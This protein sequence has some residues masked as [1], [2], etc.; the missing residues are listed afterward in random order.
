MKRSDDP[1][2]PAA[3]GRAIRRY[4][5]ETNQSDLALR[6]G[7]SQATVSNWELGIVELSCEQVGILEH[8]LGLMQG[9]L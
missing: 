6:A 4:R 2:R 9:T 3:M 5:G 8:C 7:V 1:A